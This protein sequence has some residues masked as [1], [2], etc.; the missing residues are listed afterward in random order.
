YALAPAT[1]CFLIPKNISF[2]E[3][4]TIP[5]AAM[6]A[7]LGLCKR[8]D[9]P[10][11]WRP[12]ISPIP[13]IIY[14]GAGAV[15]SLAI[16]LAQ[17]SNIHPILAVAGHSKNMSNRSLIEIRAIVSSTADLQVTHAYDAVTDHGSWNILSQVLAPSG[18]MVLVLPFGD[19][20]ILEKIS[21]FINQQSRVYS[22]RAQPLR[23][24]I[25][26]LARFFRLFE[27]GLR[28]GWFTP[29]P[30]ETIPGGLDGVEKQQLEFKVQ[31]RNM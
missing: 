15:G 25:R 23:L 1:S 5:L 20:V 12:A 8:M 19:F 13:L 18:H 24:V 26:I 28:D 9:L 2:E 6:T 16:K 14:G 11:P 10:P 22:D 17:A 4:A 21:Q 7:A 3:A 31:V 29:H 30:F 27:K